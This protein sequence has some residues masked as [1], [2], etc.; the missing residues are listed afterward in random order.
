MRLD[1]GGLNHFPRYTRL[2][3]RGGI[4]AGKWS[5]AGRHLLSHSGLC[6]REGARARGRGRSENGGAKTRFSVKQSDPRFDVLIVSCSRRE[7]V[8]QKEKQ[9]AAVRAERKGGEV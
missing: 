2:E 7:K 6:N 1:V 8:E 3:E 4:R 5:A 9:G